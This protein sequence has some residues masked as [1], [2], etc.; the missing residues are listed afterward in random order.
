MSM[1]RDEKI[2]AEIKEMNRLA[3]ESNKI[4]KPAGEGYATDDKRKTVA[5]AIRRN[6]SDRGGKGTSTT[7]MLQ[8]SRQ[9]EIS[10]MN[11]FKS[12]REQSLTVNTIT[13]ESKKYFG[14]QA[15]IEVL[16]QN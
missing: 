12:L 5:A 7:D 3:D 4:F 8:S 14:L 9:Q 2:E 11:Q 15:Q 1:T 10:L 13:S 16:E 6:N